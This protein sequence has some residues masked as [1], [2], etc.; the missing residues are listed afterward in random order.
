MDESQIVGRLERHFA[1]S[2]QLNPELVFKLGN[3]TTQRCWININVISMDRL[4]KSPNYACENPSLSKAC[5][6]KRGA[7]IQTRMAVG[8]SVSIITVG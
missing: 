1:T 4:R 7:S 6:E 5:F 2:Q 3:A 8:G